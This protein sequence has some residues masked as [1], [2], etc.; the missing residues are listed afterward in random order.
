MFAD[1]V[2]GKILC[3]RNVGIERTFTNVVD[4]A[5]NLP[6]GRSSALIIGDALADG[7]LTREVLSCKRL[8]DHS[9]SGPRRIVSFREESSPY[10]GRLERRQIIRAY[11]TLIHFVM[12]AVIWPSHNSDSV[13]VAIALDG[14][15]AGK[16]CRFNTGQ[17]CGAPHNFTIELCNLSLVA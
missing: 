1:L 3:R 13:G 11:V 17:A 2:Q 10:Q 16:S 9:H 12:F 15:P 7:V 6:D 5:D 4:Y 14:K 8:I